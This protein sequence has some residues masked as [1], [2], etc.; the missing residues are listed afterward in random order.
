[1]RVSVHRNARVRCSTT[2]ESEEGWPA[3]TTRTSGSDSVSL[4]LA[5]KA[6]S[7]GQQ[8]RWVWI[9]GSGLK[10]VRYSHIA[11]GKMGKGES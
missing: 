2:V 9:L 11:L 3:C 4:E 1:M 6:L 7:K 10:D 8:D 5:V